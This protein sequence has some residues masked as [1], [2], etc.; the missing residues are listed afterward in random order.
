MSFRK[1]ITFSPAQYSPPGGGYGGGY[2]QPIDLAGPDGK[3][4]PGPTGSG[5]DQIRISP[6]VYHDERG[7]L[8]QESMEP[9]HIIGEK[10]VQIRIDVDRDGG[11]FLDHGELAQ[12]LDAGD[13]QNVI[14]NVKS[15]ILSAKA[16]YQHAGDHR[17]K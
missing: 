13:I 9:A 10:G 17:V 6:K 15:Q 11:V 16:R 12:L 3:P 14:S 4:K 1:N 2:V 8:Y 7:R 5:N